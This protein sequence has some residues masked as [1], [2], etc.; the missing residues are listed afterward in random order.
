M[1]ST[2]LQ[3]YALVFVVLALLGGSALGLL[4]GWFVWPVRWYNTDPSDLRV[5][6]Q[7]TYVVMTADSYAVTGDGEVAKKRLYEL[8]DQDTTWDQIANLVERVAIERDNAK[9]AAAAVRVRRLAQAVGLPSATL[10]TYEPP[11]RT[12]APVSPIAIG[13]VALAV[14]LLLGAVIVSVVT[15]RAR[16][17]L[18]SDEVPVGAPVGDVPEAELANSGRPTSFG[19]PPVT[20]DVAFPTRALTAP[21]VS[22]TRVMP[23]VSA[24]TSAA[25]SPTAP[26][27]D[28]ARVPPALAENPMDEARLAVEETSEVEEQEQPSEVVWSDA[29]PGVAQP[30]PAAPPQVPPPAGALGV[31]RA[32]YSLGDDDF[33]R[34]FS[35]EAAGGDFMGECGIGISDVLPSEGPQ[36][37]DALE[38]WLFDKGDIRTVSKIVVSECAFR[39]QAQHD[40]LSAK[41][42]LLQAESGLAFSL[43]TLSLQVHATL[44]AVDYGL[45]DTAPN[46]FF[47][48]FTV[49]LVASRVALA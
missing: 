30:E 19:Q 34:S 1:S 3:R 17:G 32:T 21:P 15:Q 35:I 8:M 46:S 31:F 26:M 40:K 45:S 37:V 36:Q 48:R 27:R 22:A 14:V 43:E 16:A 10:A 44:Q 41:G 42:E 20:L 38:I 2:T 29:T 7:I 47:S 12:T 5:Q 39:D 18:P 23:V 25:A 28:P 9:D 6:H 24:P 49:E 11:T 4:M 13:G 33:D